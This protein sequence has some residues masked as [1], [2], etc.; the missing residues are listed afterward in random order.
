MEFKLVP[1]DK[2][3]VK[4]SVDKIRVVIGGVMWGIPLE[5]LDGITNEI[6]STFGT[7]KVSVEDLYKFMMSK[8]EEARKLG[9]TNLYINGDAVWFVCKE[10]HQLIYGEIK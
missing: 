2:E 9:H 4:K 7:R 1:L 3:K 8:H 5:A 10:I 6:C